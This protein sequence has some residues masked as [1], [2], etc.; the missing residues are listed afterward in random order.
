MNI[1]QTGIKPSSLRHLQCAGQFKFSIIDLP[2][3]P[4]HR[5][6]RLGSSQLFS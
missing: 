6:G 3:I 2:Y 4:S 5:Q 1:M